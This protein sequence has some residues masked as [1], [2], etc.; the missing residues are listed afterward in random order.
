VQEA[1]PAM[2]DYLVSY[3]GEHRYSWIGTSRS[4]KAGDEMAGFLYNKR[5]IDVVAHQPIW[6]AP[7]GVPRGTPGWDA[8]YPRTLETAVF[9]YSTDG[10]TGEPKQQEV[11]MLRVLNTHFDHVGVEARKR[12]SELIA[13][14]VAD[15][16]REWPQCVH[17]VTGDFNNTKIKNECYD[18]LTKGNSGLLDTARQVELGSDVVPFTIHKFEGLQ[19]SSSQGDGTV[20]LSS[21]ANAGIDGQHIDWVLYRNNSD[22][23]VKPLKYEV[24]TDRIPD[25]PYLSDHF[26]VS[27]TFGIER[28]TSIRNAVWHESQDQNATPSD[29]PIRAK[30]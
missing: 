30:L 3:L 9:F 7:D 15:G 26:P 2:L 12:S 25:G 29:G 21:D 24:M 17:V 23:Q 4:L 11:G 28:R 22:L 5:C 14:T 20:D 6:L 1:T 18:I 16:I 27:V 10:P 8:M 19:F 13:K